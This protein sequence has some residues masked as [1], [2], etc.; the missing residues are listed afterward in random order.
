M[1]R[2]L[3]FLFGLLFASCGG[4][5]SQ[6]QVLM[7][8][9]DVLSEQVTE[10]L[11]I[12][13]QPV[14]AEVATDAKV[15]IS[16]IPDTFPGSADVTLQLHTRH[17][18]S[19]ASSPLAEASL[20]F[21]LEADAAAGTF[22]GTPP[23]KN[24]ERDH[25]TA[26]M[27]LLFRSVDR[28]ATLNISNLA[29]SGPMLPAPFMLPKSMQTSWYGM[30]FDEIDRIMQES[31]AKNGELPPQPVEEIIANALT[32]VRIEEDDVEELLE[33]L[34]LWNGI[35]LLP[36]EGD[37]VRVRVESDK[38]KM[39]ASARAFLAFLEKNSLQPGQHL[40]SDPYFMELKG[41]VENDEEFAKNAGSVQGILSADK[42]TYELRGFV[43]DVYTASGAL[44]TH[45]AFINTKEKDFSLALT[46]KAGSGGTITFSKKGQEYSVDIDTKPLI[47]GTITDTALDFVFTH[48]ENGDIVMT[49]KGEILEWS[50]DWT[51]LHL[52]NVRIDIPEGKVTILLEDWNHSMSEDYKE[53]DSTLKASGM[54]N[55]KPLF[56][57]NATT[58]RKSIGAFTLESPLYKPF[59]ALQE[60]F[61]QA[62]MGG[63]EVEQE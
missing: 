9:H 22:S 25:L 29:I 28:K 16:S 8:M 38:K 59:D 2:F 20:K 57:I 31:A 17:D 42:K 19:S 48:P 21:S 5:S 14:R 32:G 24:A 4:G 43:G 11:R 50:D 3:L 12:T 13:E 54:L 36:E 51:K 58:K 47:V 10:N 45:I 27:S 53:F 34:H 35:E 6:D 37:T 41:F 55:G 23:K 7:K 30:T 60:D 49:L 26:A 44:T 61:M 62:L 40:A 63:V 52:R 1:R 46:D 39:Q 18:T 56:G 15:H 33:E